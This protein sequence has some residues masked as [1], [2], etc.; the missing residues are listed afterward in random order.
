MKKVLMV[1]FIITILV[2]GFL[3]LLSSS[4]ITGTLSDY[5]VFGMDSWLGSS[6]AG[7]TGVLLTFSLFLVLG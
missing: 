6:F 3:S 5:T 7:L 2:G 1:W 4:F